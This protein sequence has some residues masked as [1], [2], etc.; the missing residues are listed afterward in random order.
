ML[1]RAVSWIVLLFFSMLSG[2]IKLPALKGFWCRA[3]NREAVIPFRPGLPFRLPWEKRRS[4]RQPQSG[5]AG[6]VNFSDTN[7]ATALRLKN[8]TCALRVAAAATLG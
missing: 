8:F 1:L 4:I 6:D 7:D 5:C 2:N 3:L